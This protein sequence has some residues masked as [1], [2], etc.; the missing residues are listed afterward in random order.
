SEALF[1][2][3][4]EP[5]LGHNCL[6]CHDAGMNEP[7]LSAYETVI[8]QRAAALAAMK[9]GAMPPGSKLPDREIDAFAKWA[10]AVDCGARDAVDDDGGDRGDDVVQKVF[11]Y[12]DIKSMFDQACV[13]CHAPGGESPDLSTYGGARSAGASA[14]AAVQEGRM[15]PT[16]PLS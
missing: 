5:M 12:N 15:P 9:S 8:A 11:Y 1:R 3:E 10:I 4:I 2:D 13:E 14:Q 7:D 16:G 6:S